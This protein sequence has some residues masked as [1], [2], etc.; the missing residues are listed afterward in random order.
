MKDGFNRYLEMPIAKKRRV[1]RQ[2]EVIIKQLVEMRYD[3]HFL[4]NLNHDFLTVASTT[5][6]FDAEKTM[7]LAKKVNAVNKNLSIKYKTISVNIAK[8]A[9]E[10]K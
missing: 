4:A 9:K 2:T 10:M 6:L 7:K 1:D 8:L 5:S 3:S